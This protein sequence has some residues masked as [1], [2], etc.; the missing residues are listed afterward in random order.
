MLKSTQ[1][2]KGKLQSRTTCNSTIGNIHKIFKT[3]QCIC[4]VFTVS[5]DCYLSWTFVFKS[6]YRKVNFRASDRGH[7][8]VTT[9]HRLKNFDGFVLLQNATVHLVSVGAGQIRR[10]EF[11]LSEGKLFGVITAPVFTTTTRHQNTFDWLWWFSSV[12]GNV[13]T[14][15]R[16]ADSHSRVRHVIGINSGLYF[17]T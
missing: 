2:Q 12:N 5:T 3:D 13:I 10:D 6:G 4:V 15:V 8:Y 7:L 11:I 17:F 14:S 9:Q 16:S 1:N